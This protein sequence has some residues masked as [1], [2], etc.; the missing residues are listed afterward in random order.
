MC[1]AGDKE[2]GL[3]TVRRA[4]RKG[5]FVADTI[6][7][8]PAFARVREDAVYREILAEARA[9]RA[10]ALEAFRERGGE[11]LLGRAS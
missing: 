7:K 9:G 2:R 11:K 1:D 3:E 6:E 8:S 4:V 10:R 5:Y